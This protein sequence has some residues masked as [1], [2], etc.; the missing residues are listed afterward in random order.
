MPNRGVVCDLWDCLRSKRSEV[1]ILSGVP[2]TPSEINHLQLT[3]SYQSHA[4]GVAFAC[5][6]ADFAMELASNGRAV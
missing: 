2:P 1:R 6:G 3:V 4:R 5:F